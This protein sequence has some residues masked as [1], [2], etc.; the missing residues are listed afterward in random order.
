[1]KVIK[2]KKKKDFWGK[3]NY[4]S[5]KIKEETVVATMQIRVK[6]ITIIR[7]KY[8]CSVIISHSSPIQ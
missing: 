1:M 6:M 8:F 4:I 7:I 2:I 3:C 5:R